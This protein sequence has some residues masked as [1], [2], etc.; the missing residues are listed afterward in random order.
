MPHLLKVTFISSHYFTAPC[1]ISFLE[2]TNKWV[3]KQKSSSDYQLQLQKHIHILLF[4]VSL[5]RP[6]KSHQVHLHRGT[7]VKVMQEDSSP[8]VVTA[9]RPCPL[10]RNSPSAVSVSHC[11]VPAKSGP[12]A[13]PGSASPAVRHS[14]KNKSEM[15]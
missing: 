2:L 6:I 10:L 13:G 9:G 4:K 14:S 5:K 8:L 3:R 12:A 7:E 11:L 15:R 1:L